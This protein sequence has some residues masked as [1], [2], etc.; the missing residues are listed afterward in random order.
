MIEANLSYLGSSRDIVVFI[1]VAYLLNMICLNLLFFTELCMYIDFRIN[2][3][4]NFFLSQEL[5]I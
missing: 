5:Y 4:T 3:T 1:L 2:L